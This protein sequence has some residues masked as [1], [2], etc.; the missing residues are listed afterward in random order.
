MDQDFCP[1]PFSEFCVFDERAPVLPARRTLVLSPM[2]WDGVAAPPGSPDGAPPSLAS[3]AAYVGAFSGLSTR[4]LLP[5]FPIKNWG[6]RGAAA[7]VQT[8]KSLVRVRVRKSPDGDTPRQL[9]CHDLLDALLED[10]P[11]D[12]F[13]IIGVT[14]EDIYEEDA[15]VCGRAFGGSRICVVSLAE[16]LGAAAGSPEGS[17]S[18][19]ARSPASGGG[20]VSKGRG[21]RPRL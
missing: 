11:G 17:R 2:G 5:G 8:S 19:G 14:L 12:A 4:L 10:L 3:L 13:T 9:H 18:S 15:T 1:Q 21:A 7:A 6:G 20:T 16:S